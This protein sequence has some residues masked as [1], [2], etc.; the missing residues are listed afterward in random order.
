[1]FVSACADWGQCDGCFR[2]GY[3]G[4]TV[5]WVKSIQRLTSPPS[6]LLSSKPHAVIHG[7]HACARVSGAGGSVR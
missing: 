5:I 7:L 3:V 1:M 4:R 2:G 6:L